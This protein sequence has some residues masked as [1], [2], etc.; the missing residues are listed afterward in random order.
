MGALVGPRVI[1]RR[2][3]WTPIFIRPMGPK[4]SPRAARTEQPGGRSIRLTAVF[5]GSLLPEYRPQAESKWLTRHRV[6]LR[7]MPRRITIQARFI[8]QS[9]AALLTRCAIPERII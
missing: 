6:L 5:P 3:Y 1:A 9:T 7:S 4:P 2:R 8:F